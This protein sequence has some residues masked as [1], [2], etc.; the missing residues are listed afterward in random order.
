MA[1]PS[2]KR[3]QHW[4]PTMLR[5]VG[6]QCCIRLHR[7]K[8]LTGF[9]LRNNNTQQHPTT[10]GR[11]CKRTQL[12]S[13]NNV[14]SCWSTM[15]RPFC[16]TSPKTP[17]KLFEPLSGHYLTKKNSTT[18]AS[19]SVK[20]SDMCG[21]AILLASATV[22]EFCLVPRYHPSTFNFLSR[23]K[24]TLKT[25]TNILRYFYSRRPVLYKR[26]TWQKMHHFPMKST[27]RQKTT[28]IWIISARL[29]F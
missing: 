10:Y 5:V 21:A 29:N 8:S 3:T 25:S 28:A 1:S 7:A 4:L 22:W 24:I 26:R 12:V 20:K 17:L 6:Q 23:V 16:W 2:C 14:G 11:V 15:L 18:L 19:G 13:S 27:T 9:K